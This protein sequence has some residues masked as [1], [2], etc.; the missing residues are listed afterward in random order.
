[1]PKYMKA[2]FGGT[3]KDQACG[4]KFEEG[5]PIR[6]YGRGQT[7]CQKH[8]DGKGSRSQKSSQQEPVTSA[9]FSPSLAQNIAESYRKGHLDISAEDAPFIQALRDGMARAEDDT[10]NQSVTEELDNILAEWEAAD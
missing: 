1:M 9:I 5:H 8:P 6:F 4:F 3:C 10:V 7:Y 2:R